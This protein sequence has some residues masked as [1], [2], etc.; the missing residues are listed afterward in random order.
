MRKFI[1]LLVLLLVT[2]YALAVDYYISPT[3]SDANNGT[4]AS[5]AWKTLTKLNSSWGSIVSGDKI[6]FERGGTFFGSINV[7]KSGITLG[8]YGTGEKPIIT[9]FHTISSWTAAGTNRWTAAIPTSLNNIR[10]L[11][12]NNQITRVGRFPNYVDGFAGWI[13]YTNIIPKSSPVTVTSAS[14]I[15]S[16]LAD[17]ELVLMKLNWNLDVMP[18]TGISGNNITCLNPAGMWGISPS[19]YGGFGY[20][21]QNSINALDQN[22]EWHYSNSTKVLTIFSSTNPSD[23]LVKIPT[24]QN[25]I[26]IGGNSNI[27]IDGLDIQGC[28]EKGITCSGGSNITIRNCTVRYIQGWAMDLRSNNL[29]VENN[30][31]RDIGSNGVW[32]GGS[33]TFTKNALKSVGVWE[34]LPGLT[35]SGAGTQGNQD[36]QYEG[37][38]LQSSNGITCTFNEFDSTGYN[39]IKHYGSNITIEKNFI[40]FPCVTKSDGGGIYCWDNDGTLARTNRRIKNNVILN[41]GKFLYGTSTPD[42]NTNSYGIYMDGGANGAL[43]DS[44]VI[45][46]SAFSQNSACGNPTR[47]GDDAGIMMNSGTNLT[48]RGNIVFGWPDAMEMWR[49]TNMP[50]PTNNRFV[51][52]AL[53]CN[54]VGNAGDACT[55]NQSFQYHELGSSSQ[56]AVQAQ[57]QAMGYMDSNYVNDNVISPFIYKNQ[58]WFGPATKLAAWRTYSGKDA[59]SVSFP[60][61]APDFQYNETNTPKVYSFPGLSKKDFRGVVY[62]NSAIIPPFYGNIFFPNGS[63]PSGNTPVV[64]ATAT[65]ITCNGGSSTVT[66]TATGGTPPYT[67]TGIFTR[68]AGTYTFTVTD[69]NS[70]S[71]SASVTITQPDVL[72]AGN[73]TAP[74][75]TTVN[76]TT[77]ITQPVPTGGTTPYQYQLG[78]GTFQS[79]NTFNNVAAGTY[80]ITIRDACSTTITRSITIVPFVPVQ[81][82]VLDNLGLTSTTPS[83]AAY[84]LRRLSSA[85]TGA[86]V[87]VR[88]AS[89][90]ELRDVYF[91]GTGVLSLNSQVSAA[92]GGAPTAT[93]L[94]SWIGTNSATVA[95]WYDQS[96]Q[97]RNISISTTT[98]QPTIIQSGALLTNSTGQSMVRFN[99]SN[100]LT[101]SFLPTTQPVSLSAVWQFTSLPTIGSEL[102]GWG[103]NTGTGRRLGAWITTVSSSQGRFGIEYQSAS[104]IGQTLINANAWNI[105]NQV[106]T[107]SNT[108]SLTQR[109]NG[110]NETLTQGG[111]VTT[112]N[113]TAGEFAVGTIPTVNG[114]NNFNGNIQ[115]L[116]LFSSALSNTERVTIECNQSLFYSK[117]TAGNPTAPAITTAGGTT[118]IT[119]PVPTGGIAPYQYQLGTGAFQSSNTF[120]SVVAGTYTI[121]IRDACSTTITKS[122]TIASPVSPLV[123]TATATAIACNGGNSTVTVSATGGIPPYTGI[124]IFT[125]TVGTWSFTVT[126]ATGATAISSVTVIQPTVL[127]VTATATPITCVGGNSTIVIGASGGTPPYTGIGTFTRTAGTHTFVV[128]DANECS[129]TTTVTVNDPQVV[130]PVVTIGSVVSPGSVLRIDPPV[131]ITSLPTATSD[132]SVVIFP[133]PTTG[134]FNLEL[135]TT[136]RKTVSIFVYSLDGRIVFQTSSAPKNRY[137]FGSDFISGIY[138]VKVIQGDEVR[139]IEI[140]KAK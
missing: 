110:A 104:L 9:G 134:R 90:N 60:N 50:N 57:V 51:G 71:G 49:W 54:N 63:A 48:M 81:Q 127:A 86:A 47:T 102:C 140:V 80:T 3:G 111:S 130:T 98:N 107:S 136:S 95:I 10:L 116:V 12:V 108:S 20:F 85:Y 64:T 37:V 106:L 125:R 22:N 7:T 100:W 6:L 53:Y 75:I 122:I 17:G 13:R 19:L 74:A 26:T 46:P 129:I 1:K 83:A 2:N 16:N 15:N 31:I 33:G 88:H 72:T 8:S 21:L 5:T 58:S 99:G 11:T 117:L 61:T 23:R 18:V 96:G 120:S 69:A 29:R 45:G 38:L 84:S 73:P 14:A 70:V 27:V 87:R 24:I 76:G 77:T 94:G 25:L 79:T 119:Q 118:T 91:N 44:N 121:T 131:I 101:S 56:A 132:M 55:W 42:L 126:D 34:G 43:V 82:N 67:G 39:S 113:I 36:D 139:V 97:S 66:V 35:N 109:L 30:L 68:T 89:T 4:S 78:T 62:N 138:T 32:F 40:K 128:V 59:N 28:T 112:L 124:G 52:N 115:E 135:K 133:N 105:T 41:A 137:L 92:G 114:A 123:V 65:T 93:T 103:N